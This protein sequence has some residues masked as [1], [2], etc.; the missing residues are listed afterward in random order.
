MATQSASKKY[1][2]TGKVALVTGSS[3]GIGASIATQLASYGAYVTITGRNVEAITKVAHS[4]ESSGSPKPP[5]QIVGDLLDPNFAPKLVRQTVAHFGRLDILVNNAGWGH[6]SM[7]F[8][9]GDLMEAYEKVMNLNLRSAIQ[10]THLCLPE[11]EKTSG[12]VINISSVAA[13][14]PYRLLYST[15]KAALDMVT[16]CGAAEL[17]PRGIRVN[18]IK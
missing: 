17:G 16:K 1:D 10:M 5:L 7:S 13:V 6:P 4:I 2:L 12:C 14:R 3:S 8:S 9:S 15:S 18:S 11:L